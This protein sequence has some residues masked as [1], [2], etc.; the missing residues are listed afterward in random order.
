MLNNCVFAA[1][2]GTEGGVVTGSRRKFN[3]PKG[4]AVKKG[5][6]I[7]RNANYQSQRKASILNY[8]HISTRRH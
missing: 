7:N 1:D 2:G 5:L 8:V 6:K 3:L 4:C